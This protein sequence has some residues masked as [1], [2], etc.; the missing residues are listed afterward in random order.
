[1]GALA[2]WSKENDKESDDLTRKVES[3]EP[4]RSL[5]VV[6]RREPSFETELQW[7]CSEGAAHAGY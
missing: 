5:Y 2:V 4:E 3:F 1:M 7:L 6:P